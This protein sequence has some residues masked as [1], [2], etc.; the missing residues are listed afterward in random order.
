MAPPTAPSTSAARLALDFHRGGASGSGC[1][2]G[3]RDAYPSALLCLSRFLALFLSLFLPLSPSI[4]L[5]VSL[6]LSVG[7]TFVPKNDYF[8]FRLSLSRE[9]TLSHNED[10]E[11]LKTTKVKSLC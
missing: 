6:Y 9:K 1:P 3:R 5:P 8:I 10:I 2:S 4:S 7:F 11:R